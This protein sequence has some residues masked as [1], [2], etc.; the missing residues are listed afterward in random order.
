[1]NEPY[2]LGDGLK[3]VCES[4]MDKLQ[5]AGY[6]LESRNRTIINVDS[7]QVTALINALERYMREKGIY[8]DG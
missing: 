5:Y 1:M 3:N 2:N 7:Y 6:T 4:I 8:E